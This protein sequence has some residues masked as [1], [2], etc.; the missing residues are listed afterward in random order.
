LQRRPPPQRTCIACRSTTVKREL[1]RI[2]RT[3]QGTVELDLTAKKAGRGAYLH[4]SAECWQ[5]G[6]KKDRLA[7]ALKTTISNEDRKR[8]AEFAAGLT[9]VA[10]SE[11]AQ[12]RWRSNPPEPTQGAGIRERRDI[13]S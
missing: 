9:P 12:S 3:P 10:A 2:V 4:H 8:L 5:A 13:G 11:A 7:N 6:L 1:V